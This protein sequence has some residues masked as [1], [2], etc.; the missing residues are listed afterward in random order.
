M[1]GTFDGYIRSQE[2]QLCLALQ[3]ARVSAASQA[4]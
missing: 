4:N 3:A 2:N 1:K